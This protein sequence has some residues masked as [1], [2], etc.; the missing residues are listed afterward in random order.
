MVIGVGIVRDI[1][2][3][4]IEVNGDNL[5]LFGDYSVYLCGRIF[6]LWVN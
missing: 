3:V 5:V 2:W 4:V 6:I 1:V